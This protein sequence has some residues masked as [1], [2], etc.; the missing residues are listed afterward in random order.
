MWLVTSPA[1]GRGWEGRWGGPGPAHGVGWRG[2]D[3][4]M[5]QVCVSP[6]VL[7]YV[8]TFIGVSVSQAEQKGN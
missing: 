2:A 7:F 6:R 5:G 8:L 4:G 1:G 3:Q